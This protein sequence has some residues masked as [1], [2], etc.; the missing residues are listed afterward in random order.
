MKSKAVGYIRVSTEE[1]AKEGVSLSSQTDKI[2]KYS[3][4]HD[5][6]L[7]DIFSDEGVSGKSLDRTGMKKLLELTKTQSIN[8]VIVYKL[9]RL[10]RKTKDFLHLIDVFESNDVAF[11]S[12]EEKVETKSAN[13]MFFLTIMSAISQWERGIIIERT[14]E[15]LRHKRSNGD[16]L[17]RVPFGFKVLNKRLVINPDE[18]KVIQKAKRMKREGKSYRDIS[19]SLNL[20]LG[21][22][23]KIIN[24]NIK[25]LKA[26]YING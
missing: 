26:N 2:R 20:S 23:H 14:K 17:G 7:I 6:D 4:L 3:D 8:A 25:T 15:A 12:I 13:G 21:Y 19:K 10:S 24:T 11:H 1:Q 9:D 22:T 5:M 18:M 16:Y